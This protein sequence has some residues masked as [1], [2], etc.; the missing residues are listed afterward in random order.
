MGR[1]IGPDGIV[2]LVVAGYLVQAMVS[3]VVPGARPELGGNPIG[4]HVGSLVVQGLLYMMTVGLVH[5]IGRIFGG[6]GS[7]PQ[8]FLA[9]AWYSFISSFLS[10]LALAGV[11]GMTDPQPEPLSVLLLLVAVVLG[12][13]MFAGF[14]AEL[15]G[16]RNTW[17]VLAV[18]LGLAMAASVL[19]S[20]FVQPP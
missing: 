17:T 14:V 6:T 9:M 10:P 12:I 20:L 16:F 4:Y 15:H 5:V 2:G 8:A 11:V 19:L 18:T 1:E 7:L 13:R 3:I